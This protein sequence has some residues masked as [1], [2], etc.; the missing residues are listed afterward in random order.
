MFSRR[1]QLVLL[2]LV[3]LWSQAIP[4]QDNG[5][6]LAPANAQPA[7]GYTQIS[8]AEDW[9]VH[10]QTTFVAQ[11]HPRFPALFTGPNSLTPKNQARETY[12]LTFYAGL[13]P[14]RGAEI[15]VNPELDQGF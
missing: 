6:K 5:L 10:G 13:R 11:Y 8:A 7:A 1:A 3:L 9:A 2:A 4:A 15:W 14:R 12:D